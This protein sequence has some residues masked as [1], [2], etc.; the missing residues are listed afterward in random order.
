MLIYLDKGNILCKYFLF[1]ML[2]PKE[3]KALIRLPVI[4]FHNIFEKKGTKNTLFI[5]VAKFLDNVLLRYAIKF[6]KAITSACRVLI[7]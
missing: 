2:Y 7:S 4:N 5:V 3:L 1:Y 6:K